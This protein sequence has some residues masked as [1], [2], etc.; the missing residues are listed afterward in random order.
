VCNRG[1][2]LRKRCLAR[3]SDTLPFVRVTRTF[4]DASF[5]KWHAK[6]GGMDASDAERLKELEL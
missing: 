5:K 1:K 6:Y 2:Q 4:G 3:K